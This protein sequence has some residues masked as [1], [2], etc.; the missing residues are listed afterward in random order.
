[1]TENLNPHWSEIVFKVYLV[2][3]REYG[4]ENPKLRGIRRSQESAN[5]FAED[6]KKEYQDSTGHWYHGKIA[7]IFIVETECHP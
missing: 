4:V 5:K 2:Y 3:V 7:E 6:L 1:M